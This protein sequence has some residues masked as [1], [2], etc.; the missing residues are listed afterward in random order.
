MRSNNFLNYSIGNILTKGITYISSLAFAYFLST[1]EYGI[2]SLFYSIVPLIIVISSLNLPS[3]IRQYEYKYGRNSESYLSQIASITILIQLTILIVFL[4]NKAYFLRFLELPTNFSYLISCIIIIGPIVMIGEQFYLGRNNSLRYT[5]IGLI[6]S[7]L[8]LL[9]SLS[10]VFIFFESAFY[11]SLGVVISYLITGVY[12]TYHLFPFWKTP[13]WL[14]TK[15]LKYA[16]TFSLPIIIHQISNTLLAVS[17]RIVIS[18][19]LG[20][21]QTGIYSFAYSL[22]SLLFVLIIALNQAVV[23]KYYI[24]LKQN[25]RKEIL[26][27]FSLFS[28]VTAILVPLSSVILCIIFNLLSPKEYF[29]GVDIIPV[30]LNV[31]F[32]IECYLYYVNQNFYYN[33]VLQI[34]VGTII[35]AILNIALNLIFIQKIG[36]LFGAISTW[37]AYF[38][39]A[40]YNYLICQNKDKGNDTGQ[41]LVIIKILTLSTP[42]LILS[43]IF[44]PSEHFNLYIL[45]Q[46][47]YLISIVLATK[48]W[49]KLYFILR[50]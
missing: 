18:K 30:I 46:L 1:E 19:V 15:Y 6:K 36:I 3:S 28:E 2:Y 12:V 24:L 7:I 42:H 31:A 48:N 44:K 50:K 29:N 27:Y 43:I 45:I 21:S 40:I 39:L 33:R 4:F 10:L 38:L 22:G 20:N 8:E 17:D 13:R 41:G 47:I 5:Y 49:K 14:N 35:C 11:R 32:A 9:I 23:K 16:I 25:K 37:I 34:S 26:E